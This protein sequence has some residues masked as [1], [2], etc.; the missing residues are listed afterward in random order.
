[1]KYGVILGLASFAFGMVLFM[2]NQTGNTALSLITYAIIIGAIVMAIREYKSLTGGFISF[3]KAFGLGFLTS[4]I[5]GVI[6]SLGTFVYVMIDQTA[7]PRMIDQT[8]MELEKNP[9]M[10]EEMIDMTMGFTEKLMSPVPLLLVG[11]VSSLFAGA[12]ISLI[13]AAIMKKDDPGF[14][15]IDEMGE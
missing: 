9:D 7:I 8:R 12:I 6:S 10:T 5:G 14:G 11:I 3:K 2:T 4:L 1:M 15:V 13:I